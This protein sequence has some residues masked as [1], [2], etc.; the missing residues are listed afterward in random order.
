[1]GLVYQEF[2]DDCETNYLLTEEELD[3]GKF[4]IVSF[5]KDTM[6]WTR[7]VDNIYDEIGGSS[8][9]RIPF[10]INGKWGYF[11]TNGT[12]VI[13]PIYD[14]A[15]EFWDYSKDGKDVT[16]YAEV[17]I[18]GDSVLIDKYGVVQNCTLYIKNY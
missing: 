3:N 18:R 13:E 1:M 7:L 12:I 14:Y 10:K 4:G 17:V 15:T 11:D 16:P 9:D 5:N 8:C 2:L 6:E